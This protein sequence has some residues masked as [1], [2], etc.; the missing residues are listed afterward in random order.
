MRIVDRKVSELN[1]KLKSIEEEFRQW[2]GQSA[3]G[4]PLEKHHTQI[5]RITAQLDGLRGSI[6]DSLHRIVD[7][8]NVLGRCRKLERMIL[9]I[10]RIWDFFRSKLIIRNVAYFKPYLTAADEFAWLCYRSAQEKANADSISPETVKEPPLV[11]FNGGSSPYTTSRNRSYQ[12]ESVPHEE[13]DFETCANVL[14]A[15]P[16]PVIGIPWFQIDHLPDALVIAHE[17]GHN[18]EDDFKLTLRLRS[19]I[20]DAMAA[21]QISDRRKRAWRAWQGELFAD[22]YGCLSA[23]PAFAGSLMDFLA[24]DNAIIKGEKQI[25]PAWNIYPPDYLRILFNLEVLR[26]QGFETESERLGENWK[27]TYASHAMTEFENDIPIIVKAFLKGTFPEFGGICLSD[28]MSFSV[29]DHQKAVKT[30]DH[31]IRQIQLSEEKINILF[32]AARL[33]FER[34]PQDYQARD[35]RGRIINHINDVQ[36]TGVRAG[37]ERKTTNELE[38]LE[39]MDKKAGENLYDLFSRLLDD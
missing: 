8:E 3:P 18:V 26:Q 14:K 22:I 10:H 33:S 7:N 4:A 20:E 5:L 9:E 17:V 2:R 35:V 13:I 36:N 23:G 38:K 21:S 12:A 16:V 28:L 30:A 37:E 15:L 31:A 27:A 34:S 19:I 1:Q 11:F 32:A 24:R 6:C 25:D 29:T 39:I